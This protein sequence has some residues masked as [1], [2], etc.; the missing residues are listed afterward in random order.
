VNLDGAVTLIT[1]ASSGIGE[2]T[3]RLLW[4]RGGRLVLGA[5][6]QD[7]LDALVA[8]L[9][10]E[11]T[12]ARA[13]DVREE[14]DVRG[15]VALVRER[16]G[17]L[18]AVFANAGF[19]GGGGIVEGDPAHWRE[20][21]LT[22]VHGLA[23]TLHHAVP[24]ILDSGP[25]GHAVLTSS[26]AGRRTPSGSANYL[27]AASKFAVVAIGEGL[28]QGLAGRVQVTLIEPGAV[29]TDFFEERP[30]EVLSPDDIARAV[31]FSLEQPHG[32][33]VNEVLV[34]P[35]GQKN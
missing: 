22:N 9:G 32:V 25:D 29:D 5:R 11:R 13:C 1:G 31:A 30:S 15:L 18:D 3:A 35:L 26:V 16:F 23:L 21:L 7:R 19:G 14:D 28:R 10:P 34:R 2:A 20:M 24:L 8:E 17:R 33:A 6:R 12:A 27:Y 4:A